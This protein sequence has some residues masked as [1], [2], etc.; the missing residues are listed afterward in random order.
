MKLAIIQDP[1]THLL[2]VDVTQNANGTFVL[3]RHKLLMTVVG[4]QAAAEALARLPEARLHVGLSTGPQ[5]LRWTAEH[6]FVEK[7]YHTDIT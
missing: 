1:V 6:V 7:G 3:T 2:A 5:S 4:N